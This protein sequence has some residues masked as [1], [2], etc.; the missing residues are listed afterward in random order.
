M[1]L[2]RNGQIHQLLAFPTALWPLISCCCNWSSN[3]WSQIKFYTS[4]NITFFSINYIFGAFDPTLIL[5]GYFF[6][7]KTKLDVFWSSIL[8]GTKLCVKFL[9][10]QNKD[11]CTR[12]ELKEAIRATFDLSTLCLHINKRIN[13]KNKAVSSAL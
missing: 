13:Y 3:M 4:D 10:Y 1:I 8:I 2:K 12:D 11:Q 6:W 5:A 9:W 7:G